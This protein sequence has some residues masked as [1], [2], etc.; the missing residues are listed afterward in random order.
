MWV[1]L[2]LSPWEVLCWRQCPHRGGPD[3][4]QTSIGCP[5]FLIKTRLP[6]AAKEQDAPNS[7]TPSSRA[8]RLNYSY[9]THLLLWFTARAMSAIAN[10]L[11]FTREFVF[12]SHCLS[13]NNCWLIFK[14]YK[15][16]TILQVKVW[17]FLHT[18]A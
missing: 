11:L 13:I 1:T 8:A 18:F 7:A 12:M 5:R 6:S 9:V 17:S 15:F 16:K 4:R 14:F 3:W 10:Y 2:L